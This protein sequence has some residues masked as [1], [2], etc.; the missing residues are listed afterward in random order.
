MEVKGVRRVD[1]HE[2]RSIATFAGD[3]KPKKTFVVCNETARRKVGQVLVVPWREFLKE[4]W[5]NEVV[6]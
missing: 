2:L 5:A 6:E 3:Y 1:S 4:L